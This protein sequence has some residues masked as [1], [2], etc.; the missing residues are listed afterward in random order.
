MP[1]EI[2]YKQQID[3]AIRGF[4]NKSLSESAFNLFETLGYRSEKRLSLQP[5]T[6][7]QFCIEFDAEKE[8]KEK[9]LLSEWKQVEFLFQLTDD[10]IN[11]S[12]GQISLF[13]SKKVDNTIINSYLFF[14]IQLK[15]QQYTRTQLADI[16]REVNKLFSMPVMI[17]FQHGQ[18]LTLSIVARRLNKRDAS[19]K[20]VLEKVTLIKDISISSPHRAHIEILFDISIGQ[21]NAA[22]SFTNFVELQKAWEKT[23]DTSELNKK[24][25]KEIANWYFWAVQNVKFP[26]GENNDTEENRNAINVI[27]LI[28]RLIFVWFLKEKSLIPEDLFNESKIRQM[29]KFEDAHDSTYYKAIFQNLF[30]ATLNQEMNTPQKPDSRKFRVQSKQPGGRDGNR[31]VT[32]LYRYESYFKNPQDALA[33][34]STI[35]FLNGGLFECLDKEIEKD[36]Q[37]VVIRIDGFSDEEK[38]PLS[39][40]DSLFFSPETNIDLNNVYDT[41]NKRYQVSGLIHILSRYKFT[42]EE[43]TPIT[44]EIALDPELLGKVFENLLASFN[45]E[46]RTTARKQTGSYYTPREIVNYM[47]DESLIAY[48]ENYLTERI[49][50]QQLQAKALFATQPT[51]TGENQPALEIQ[52]DIHTRLRHLLAYNEQPPLFS[53]TETVHLIEA[54]D[55]INVLDPACGSGAFPMGILHKLVFVLSRLDPGNLRWKQKQI[56]KANEIL[57]T[58]VRERVIEDIEQTFSANELDYG[59]KLYLIENCIFGVD[60]QPI[61]VQ[62]SKLRFFISLIVDQKID[63]HQDNRGIRPLPN[64]ETKFVAANTLIS[65]DKP[66]QLTLPNPEIA[67]LE[68]KLTE[69]R[70]KH[71]TARTPQTKRKFREEDA[72][73]RKELGKLLQKDGYQRGETEKLAD[74]NPYEQNQPANFFDAEWMFG[75]SEGF[76]IVIGNPPYI[77]IEKFARTQLQSSWR[78]KYST[79]ASRGDI[80]C[81]FYEQGINLLTQHGILAFITSNKFMRAGYGKGLR[82]LLT[83]HQLLSLIDFCELPVFE[84]STDP[85]IIV[86]SKTATTPSLEFPI[87]VVKNEFEIYS[88]TETVNT[89]SKKISSHHLKIDGWSLDGIDNIELVRKIHSAGKPL[90]EYV[91]GQIYYGVKTGLNEAFVI[92]RETRDRLIF[93]DSK[94]KELIRPWIRGKDIKRWTYEFHDFYVLIIPFGFHKELNKY[95]AVLK[96]LSQFEGKLKMRGQCLTSRDGSNT[97]QHHWLELDNNPSESYIAS[98]NKPKIVFN[99]TSKRLHAYIDNAGNIINKTGFFIISPE[100]PFI[101]AIMNSSLMDWFYRSTFPSWGDPWTNGRV[102]FRGNLMG[103][104]PIPHAE[105]IDKQNLTNMV[106]DASKFASQGDLNSVNIIE[107]KIDEIVYRL[108]NISANDIERIE[109]S[110]ENTR[111]TNESDKD[112]EDENFAEEKIW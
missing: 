90:V 10:E 77:S 49:D 33:L 40:P 79:F 107:K 50:Q 109:T 76:N 20:D 106:D 38:N 56:D 89:R 15:N 2:E 66:Q 111:N 58:T 26:V 41:R 59:R 18:S 65:I 84:A 55:S 82:Q 42:I 44:E 94:S 63:N 39:V 43:N 80:Y 51:L 28:T 91:Y 37:N 108:Y 104:I 86:L 60:I 54:I 12:L 8:L 92:N 19:R 30:F 9:A 45:P 16:T 98:F 75:I 83:S 32:N 17:L 46:T 97:G 52:Q 27:R 5:N 13:S 67:R 88:L 4:A 96:H 22:Y 103:K 68:K 78:K 53:E 101:L 70:Q 105:T 72:L 71:F 47:V 69:I 21:L 48:F 62:I 74:W 99:E 73:I 81:L 6:P 14:A 35:P 23:L 102:Q 61:A 7:E 1:A 85:M 100:A 93:E 64:L 24:F 11:A 29:L 57:D 112:N 31:L 36:G 34:F 110:L 3:N 25:F 87:L 95:P